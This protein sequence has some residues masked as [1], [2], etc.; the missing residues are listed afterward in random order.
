[1]RLLIRHIYLLALPPVLLRRLLAG[2]G[3]TGFADFSRKK[4]RSPVGTKPG[5]ANKELDIIVVK[6][7]E[8]FPIT[9]VGNDRV[10]EKIFVVRSVLGSLEKGEAPFECQKKPDKPPKYNSR[11]TQ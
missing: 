2:L 11:E 9:T 8:G 7:Q 10:G 3:V 5:I 6:T 4:S 1:M